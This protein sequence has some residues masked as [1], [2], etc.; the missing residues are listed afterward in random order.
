MPHQGQSTYDSALLLKGIP[1]YS[2]SE[3]NLT[4]KSRASPPVTTKN[5][6]EKLLFMDEKIFTIEERYNNQ[7]N[8]IYAET[9]LQVHSVGAGG[10]HSSYIVVWLGGPVRG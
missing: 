1:H 5:G 6:H 3:G 4:D 10:Q 9:S 8:K 2:C 7:Y